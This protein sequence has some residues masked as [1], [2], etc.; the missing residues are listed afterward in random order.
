[1]T[2][3]GA[4]NLCDEKCGDGNVHRWLIDPYGTDNMETI[5]IPFNGLEI[6]VIHSRHGHGEGEVVPDGLFLGLD[7]EILEPN[8]I[9]RKKYLFGMMKQNIHSAPLL[10]RMIILENLVHARLGFVK[11]N[12]APHEPIID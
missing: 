5:V 3:N 11:D 10:V 6:N 7:V 12:W 8:P 2:Q 9:D 1:M 4:Y